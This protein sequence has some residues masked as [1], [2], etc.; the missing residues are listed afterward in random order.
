[1]YEQVEALLQS[2]APQRSAED[3]ARA[4]RALWGGVQ[5]ICVL[6][7][8]DK[9]DIDRI[10]TLSE[11]ADSLVGDYLAGLGARH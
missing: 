6:A 8:S 10:E 2:V 11:V 7:L 1:M 5:G 3:I 9:L 4:A